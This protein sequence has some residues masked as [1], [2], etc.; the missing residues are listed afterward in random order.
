[1]S[2]EFLPLIDEDGNVI[3]KA[4][5]SECHGGSFLLH[6]VVHLHIF[7]SKGRLYLQKRSMSKKLLP[8]YWDTAVGG[9]VDYGESV[10]E[11]LLRET[12]EELGVT[13]ADIK[14][15]FTYL[16]RSMTEYEQVNAF[17]T[18]YE[19]PIC[20]DA[21]EVSDGR[22]FSFE[23][24]EGLVGKDT[25]TP[26]FELEFGKIKEKLYSHNNISINI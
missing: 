12:R 17:Y 6:P 3:G 11:A 9:H 16:Y 22:F 8:G 19:G 25:L 4:L 14:P 1:M 23:E 21:S 2:E 20:P 26:N 18:V 24:I 5:R 15:L 13:D 7:D 10:K